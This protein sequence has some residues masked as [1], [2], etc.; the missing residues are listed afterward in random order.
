MRT[1]DGE[2]REDSGDVP[3]EASVQLGDCWCH[4]VA[5]SRVPSRTSGQRAEADGT[6]KQGKVW[7]G[8]SWQDRG[9]SA[10]RSAQ[11]RVLRVPEPKIGQGPRSPPNPIPHF[12][13]I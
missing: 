3:R 4:H 9:G 11:N 10:G 5:V 12:I 6:G 8:T 13:D 2:E 1:W 7:L